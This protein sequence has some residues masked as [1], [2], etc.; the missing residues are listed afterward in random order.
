MAA[1]STVVVP[2]LTFSLLLVVLCPLSCS[3]PGTYN[4][5]LRADT[6]TACTT[7]AAGLST[8]T[9]GGRDSSACDVC[10]TGYGGTNCAAQC[11]GGSG[12]N[13]TFG[14]AGRA[15]GAN[16][17]ACPTM[18]TGFS[19]DYLGQNRAFTPNPLARLGADSPADCLAEFAQIAD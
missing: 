18:S 7:C 13:A 11:G 4:D 6:A 2:R 9:T 1:P 10:A 14:V 12:V 15:R 8:S 17:D 19:F 5:L 3:P 16:C